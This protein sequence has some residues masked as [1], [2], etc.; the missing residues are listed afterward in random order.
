MSGK[1][2][3][4]LWERLNPIRT[5]RS[6]KNGIDSLVDNLQT[7]PSSGVI[8]GVPKTKKR[9]GHCLSLVMGPGKSI[10][11]VRACHDPVMAILP[12]EANRLIREYWEKGFV[13]PI[14]VVTNNR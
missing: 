6:L 9:E 2:C 5:R 3:L 12:E 10:V 1:A 7:D 14:R 4:T 11:M 8:L 13:R